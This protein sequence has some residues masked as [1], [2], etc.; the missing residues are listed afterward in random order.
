MQKVNVISFFEEN[1]STYSYLVHAEGS[2]ECAV[3][4][5]VLNYE[6]NSA[7]ISTHFA[8]KIVDYIQKNQL[9]LQ[10]LLETHVHADHLSASAWLKEQLG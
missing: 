4:D 8:Q 2:P 6:P 10:W 7:R 5:S 3:I 1:T 9:Q